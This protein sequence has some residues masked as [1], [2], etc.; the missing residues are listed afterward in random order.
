MDTALF[1]P[2]YMGLSSTQATALLLR[3]AD[4]AN[5]FGGCF[6]MNWHDRS[7]AP[8]RLWDTCYRRA[9]SGLRDRNA[10]FATAGQAAAWFRLRRSVLF[11]PDEDTGDGRHVRILSDDGDN[12]PGLCFRVYSQQPT[13]PTAASRLSAFKDRKMDRV[14][15]AQRACRGSLS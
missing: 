13:S 2:T 5:R 3:L 7:L 15:E 1:Y 4:D 9:I 6:T 10:W 12:L 11:E 14:A 8:E